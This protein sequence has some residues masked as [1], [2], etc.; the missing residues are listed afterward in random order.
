M[1]HKQ[2]SM[3]SDTVDWTYTYIPVV[4]FLSFFVKMYLVHIWAGLGLGWIWSTGQSREVWTW[5]LTL[6]VPDVNTKWILMLLDDRGPCVYVQQYQWIPLCQL[7]ASD[8]HLHPIIEGEDGGSAGVVGPLFHITDGL[9]EV[10]PAGQTSSRRGGGSWAL[11]CCWCCLRRLRY[12]Y[13]LLSFQSGS[14]PT[15]AVIGSP[16]ITFPVGVDTS[17]R[18]IWFRHRRRPGPV[19]YRLIAG[20]LLGTCLALDSSASTPWTSVSS[21]STKGA[22]E[23]LWAVVFHRRFLLLGFTY[24]GVGVCNLRTHAEG[25]KSMVSV[26]NPELHAALACSLWVTGP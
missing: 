19:S 17:V 13:R 6:F 12:R 23:G 7:Q 1:K 14:T 21:L 26:N 22:W 16:L 8:V 2:V 3:A 4:L 15:C 11:R 24:N 5:I 25:E 20:L 10:F 9:I 18:R